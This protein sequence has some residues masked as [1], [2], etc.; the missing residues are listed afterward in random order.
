MLKRENLADH[1]KAFDYLPHDLF[2]VKMQAYEFDTKSLRLIK[3][4][5]SSRMQGTK[6]GRKYSSFPVC[7]LIIS[8]T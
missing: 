5:L 1:L 4:K 2:I 7:Q 3:D 6:D 8:L